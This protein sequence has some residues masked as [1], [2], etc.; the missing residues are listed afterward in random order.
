LGEAP[1]EL[2]RAVRAE[3]AVAATLALVVAEAARRMG[4]EAPAAVALT[5]PAS[6]PNKRLSALRDAARAAGLERVELVAEPVAAAR[7]L[8]GPEVGVGEALAV[9]DLGGGTFDTAVLRR[10]GEGGFDTLAVGGQDGLGGEVFDARLVRHLG[11]LL[12]EADPAEWEAIERSPRALADLRREARAAKE[13]LSRNNTTEVILPTVIERPSLRLTR[14]ELE[15][16]VEPD[17]RRSADI[18]AETV[19]AAGVQPAELRTVFLVGGA[20][21]MPLV[22]RV[23]GE[24]FG[25]V[26]ETREDP[27]AV[28]VLGAAAKDQQPVAPEPTEADVLASRSPRNPAG[29]TA[30]P[31]RRAR[32]DPDAFTEYDEAPAIHPDSATEYDPQDGSQQFARTA[33]SVAADRWKVILGWA[34]V[35]LVYLVGAYLLFGR[36]LLDQPA[37][38]SQEEAERRATSD[39]ALADANLRAG[40]T[41]DCDARP[42]L[43]T[44]WSCKVSGGVCTA[45]VTVSEETTFVT[46][47]ATDS[48]PFP[49]DR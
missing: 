40:A 31:T 28:V 39:E 18:L 37:S 3:E 45:L 49:C 17:V 44:V 10:R 4:G 25:R 13:A 24:H 27:K 47:P 12:R 43:D 21:R 5:H 30:A 15:R 16:L 6:W 35:V 19:A 26:P 48:S 29:L 41:A 2:G 32:P 23:L 9:Y 22:A 46:R 34:G 38:L 42:G 11:A 20:S 33:P 36:A 1:L 7:H 14:K 8:A